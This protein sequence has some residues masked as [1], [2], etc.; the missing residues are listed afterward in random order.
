MERGPPNQE[1]E[2]WQRL[3]LDFPLLS[4]TSPLPF[5]PI[6]LGTDMLCLYLST[7]LSVFTDASVGNFGAA[8]SEF[9]LLIYAQTTLQS[10]LQQAAGSILF[11]I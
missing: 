10:S 5:T 3:P 6:L 9:S 2:K 1:T 11:K 8:S 4:L 7:Y